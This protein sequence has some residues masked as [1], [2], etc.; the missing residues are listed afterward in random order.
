MIRET[1]G[2]RVSEQMRERADVV[3]ATLLIVNMGSVLPQGHLMKCVVGDS[4]TFLF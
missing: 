2:W 3:L 1:S 4:G